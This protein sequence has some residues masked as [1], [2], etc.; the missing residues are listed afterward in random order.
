MP[1]SVSRTSATV[2]E[3]SSAAASTGRPAASTPQIRLG[4]MKP[5]SPRARP[6]KC[7]SAL[8]SDSG[9]TSRGWYGRNETEST[10]ST[11]A[12]ER[13]LGV[14]RAGPDDH[15]PEVVEVAEQRGGANQRVEILRVA[16]V[17]GVHDDEAVGEPVLARPLGCRAAAA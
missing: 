8:A 1:Q 9:S 3:S 7:T 10:S 15:D 13:E 12:S 6:T 4:T 14:A 2:S 16:D 5:A 11:S 17:A